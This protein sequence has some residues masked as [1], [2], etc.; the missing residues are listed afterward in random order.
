MLFLFIG[1]VKE[2]IIVYAEE[3]A[4]VI[5]D[6]MEITEETVTYKEPNRESE[7]GEVIPK[8]ENVLIVSKTGDGWY[9]ILYHETILY[10]PTNE[11]SLE[12]LEIPEDVIEEIEQKKEET[13][14]LTKDEVETLVDDGVI[15]DGPIYEEVI[16]EK[17]LQRKNERMETLPKL[18]L[19][20][21][22]LIVVTSGIGC[23]LIK[24]KEELEQIK[25]QKQ[26]DIVVENLDAED[27]E[28][29]V[30]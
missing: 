10:F 12:E 17:E 2:R 5:Y 16:A 25:K 28:E 9:Q 11:Q 22:F 23:F 18:L 15:T 4:Q 30:Q 7:T 14:D 26:E 27:D 6:F 8:G 1:C 21:L 19:G 3:Q 24:K 20:G 29:M 13:Q